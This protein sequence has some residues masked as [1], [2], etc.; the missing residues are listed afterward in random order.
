MFHVTCGRRGV[1]KILYCHGAADRILS[2]YSRFIL[3]CD[4]EKNKNK[5]LR[6]V[7]RGVC[8]VVWLVVAVSSVV[9]VPVAGKPSR[10]AIVS[11][12]PP[13]QVIS[14][15]RR[16]RWPRNAWHSSVS[17]PEPFSNSRRLASSTAAGRLP[18]RD[19]RVIGPAGGA[20]SRVV[21]AAWLRCGRGDVL[22]KTWKTISSVI[23]LH[24]VRKGKKTTGRGKSERKNPK[25]SF[26]PWKFR[27][28]GTGPR[29]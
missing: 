3:S 13:D 4:K 15:R 11:Q 16:R 18:S 7:T 14:P 12:R 20:A 19:C 2:F 21:R 29:D 17:L 26:T 5:I 28:R 10:H 25:K 1:F 24:R 22:P 9:R 6:T 27:R 23:V 8:R